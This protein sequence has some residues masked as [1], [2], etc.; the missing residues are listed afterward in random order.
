VGGIALLLLIILVA[1]V[2]AL[3]VAFSSGGGASAGPTVYEEEYVSGAGTDRVAVIPVQ[4]VIASG[5]PALG[6]VQ[7]TVTPEGFSDA[8][9]QAADDA[10][11]VAVVLEVNSP[12]G[13]VTA[14]DEMH[15]SI[16]DFQERADKPVIVSMG[17]TAASGGYYISAPA[18]AIVAN[19]TTLT[20]S[21]GAI[22][23]LTDVSGLAEDY[24]VKQEVIK[25]GEFKDIF[26]SFRELTP[27]EREILQSIVD[28][29]Y[30][31]FVDVIS[32]G[33]QIPEDRVREIADGRVYSGEQARELGLID[34]LGGLDE[35]ARL[36]RDRARVNGAT[37]IRYVQTP[38]LFDTV[39]ARLAPREPEA[40]QILRAIGFDPTP[41]VQYLYRPGV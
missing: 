37:V 15:Q 26:S 28:E 25:S 14:S 16:V 34:E 35:A 24:G 11:V 10:S 12:G 22:I 18:D 20:G 13:G 23:T 5:D 39:T 30:S 31:E 17:D 7:P 3:A 41:K 29:S 1:S 40:I 36:A 4:G 2:I 8:L 32:Q 9:G 6:G 27:Q 19:E 38:G 21:L 33:R